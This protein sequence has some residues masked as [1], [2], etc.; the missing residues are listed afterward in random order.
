MVLVEEIVE[1]EDASESKATIVEEVQEAKAAISKGFLEKAKDKPLYGPE[2]SAEG[3]VDPKT[4]KAHAE[5][6]MNEDLNAGMNRGTER[7]AW[8]AG[9]EEPEEPAGIEEYHLSDGETPKPR[10][11]WSPGLSTMFD[12]DLINNCVQ[13]AKKAQ[14]ADAATQTEPE[15]A[16]AE[17][18]L[19]RLRRQ[20]LEERQRRRS[21]EQELEECQDCQYNAPGCALDELDTS[22]HASDLHKGMVQNC[23]RWQEALAPGV[24]SMRFSFLQATDEDLNHIIEKL[25]GN[26]DVTE[27]DLSHNHIKDTGV[28]ALVA[29]L[30]AGAAPKLRELRLY[31]NEFGALG[32][33]MLKQGLAVFR[34]DLKVQSQ[35]PSWAKLAREQVQVLSLLKITESASDESCELAWQSILGGKD[36][37]ALCPASAWPDVVLPALCRSQHGLPVLVLV[38]DAVDILAAQ[39]GEWSQAL[40]ATATS[41][42]WTD[43]VFFTSCGQ[44]PLGPFTSSQEVLSPEMIPQQPNP[45]WQIL[46]ILHSKECPLLREQLQLLPAPSQVILAVESWDEYTRE[47]AGDILHDSV[48][49]TLRQ[50]QSQSEKTEDVD[51][52]AVHMA[53]ILCRSEDAGLRTA[54]RAM[55]GVG[56]GQGQTRSEVGCKRKACTQGEAQ[57]GS[58][59]LEEAELRRGIAALLAR[60]Q[61]VTAKKS[62]PKGCKGRKTSKPVRRAVQLEDWDDCESENSDF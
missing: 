33:T 2:G 8:A 19:R 31:S 1:E 57:P 6:K 23:G 52:I 53:N 35:E 26:E 48:E 7:W 14:V 21:A 24:A 39:V 25:K 20:L 47:L 34:K 60:H 45:G 62:M 59:E 49:L 4:H 12:N 42:A 15:G 27:L 18:A 41:G 13:D 9:P 44:P 56:F 37:A 40:A 32:E 16:S 10:E 3:K 17:A 50:A 36:V 29:A 61:E 11:P 38:T 51:L 5:H 30:A 28:Q 43:M 55:L 22:Q 58:I 46:V 54:V